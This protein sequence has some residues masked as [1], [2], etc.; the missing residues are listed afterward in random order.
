MTVRNSDGTLEPSIGDIGLLCSPSHPS[1]GLVIWCFE[2]PVMVTR[3]DP[4]TGGHVEL[5]VTFLAACGDCCLRHR[6]DPS[7]IAAHATGHLTWQ[8]AESASPRS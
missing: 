8:P 2:E 6:T 4:A 5:T 1:D 7:V 3:V